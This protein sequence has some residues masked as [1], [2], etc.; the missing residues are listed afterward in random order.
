MVGPAEAFLLSGV[1]TSGSLADRYTFPTDFT[2]WANLLL[3]ML[4]TDMD[5]SVP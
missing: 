4:L 1:G 5:T 2:S 3:F